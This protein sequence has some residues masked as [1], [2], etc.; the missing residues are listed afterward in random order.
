MGWTAADIGDLSGLAAVVTGANS[1]IG[2]IAAGE[3]ARRGAATVLACRDVAKGEAAAQL[4][5]KA[6]PHASIEV[7]QLDLADLASV[8]AFAAAYTGGLDVLVN[9]AGV[10]ALPYRQTVDGFEMQFG[11]N[12]LGHFALTGLLLPRL[13]ERP[14]PRV[15]TVSSGLHKGG[16]IDFDDLQGERSYRKW[17]AYGQSKLANLLFAY[18]LQRRAAGAL[19]SVAAHPGYAAT[20]LQAVGPRMEGNPILE[21]GSRLGNVLFAQSAERGALPL[22]YAATERGLAGGTYVGPDGRFGSRG[23][24]TPIDSSP[25]SKDRAVAARLWSVSEAL[26][27]VHYDFPADTAPA[28]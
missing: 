11:T 12:H 15:V 28:K 26:T 16:H 8:R 21:F 6:A 9:N 25:A 24:P 17:A 18:E 13:L 7:R 19:T 5:K 10:M 4:M 20:N 14:D 27:G 2:M 3:L 23:Y 22:L 1:G